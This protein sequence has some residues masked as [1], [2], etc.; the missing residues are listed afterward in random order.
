[1]T[2]QPLPGEKPAGM[3]RRLAKVL[4][5]KNAIVVRHEIFESVTARKEI[6]RALQQEI[7]NDWWPVMWIRGGKDTDNAISG[8]HVFAVAGTRVQTICTDGQPVGRVF[9]D[10][11]IRHCVLAGMKP[12]NL[13]VSKLAQCREVF[14]NLERVLREAD[15]NMADVVRTWFFLDDIHS[16]YG[17]FN[18]TRIEFFKKKKLLGGLLPASTGI[19]G[20]NPFGAALVAGAWAVQAM[21]SSVAVHAVPSPLQ[22]SSMEYGSAFSRAV[23]VDT[24]SC[25]RLLISGTASIGP[26]GRSLHTGDLHKQIGL[27]MKVVREILGSCGFDF[28]HITRA[29][30]YF[31][32]IQ[33]IPAFDLWRERQ[34]LEPFPLIATQSDICRPELLFEIEL[35]AI[36]SET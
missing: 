34:G 1:M 9:D 30:A 33:D 15:M 26:D 8:M 25:R 28:S 18:N 17:E 13:S 20:Q 27:S 2:L 16:W 7:Q 11:Q 6:M 35:D 3:V 12:T 23:S 21:N 36:S 22:C 31:K 4:R 24:L 14:S 19:G 29:T 5:E 10:G 32:N